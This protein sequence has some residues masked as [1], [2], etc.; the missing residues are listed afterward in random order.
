MGAIRSSAAVTPTLSANLVPKAEL[1]KP[2]RGT[3][4]IGDSE[5]FIIFVFILYCVF[6]APGSLHRVEKKLA[7]QLFFNQAK[8]REIL[9]EEGKRA[10]AM[11]G[12]KTGDGHDMASAT[13]LAV[14]G[15]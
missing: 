6:Q 9:E 8:K 3:M 13:T 5:D 14:P 10:A 15:V 7:F 12:G 11:V 2:F 4:G 1:Y